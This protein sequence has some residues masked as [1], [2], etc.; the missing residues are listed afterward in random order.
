MR[1]NS[2]ERSLFAVPRCTALW[3]TRETQLSL[4]MWLTGVQAC[5]AA[6]KPSMQMRLDPQIQGLKFPPWELTPE[7][8][9]LSWDGSF[10]LEGGQSGV[11]ATGVK[12]AWVSLLS[13]LCGSPKA[14]E[15]VPSCMSQNI[16]GR[17][18]LE[19][20]N[21]FGNYPGVFRISSLYTNYTAWK[22]VWG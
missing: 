7:D 20:T 8:S 15:L 21:R 18:S 5:S 17:D 10:G 22:I 16:W 4:L 9:P 6:G 1:R 13:N 11:D 12:A 14:L 3:K 2:W 19:S